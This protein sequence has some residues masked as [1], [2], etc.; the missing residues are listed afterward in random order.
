VLEDIAMA[1]LDPR[2]VQLITH[3]YLRRV[4]ERS[5]RPLDE[6]NLNEIVR[7]MP[8]PGPRLVDMAMAERMHLPEDKRMQEVA[9]LMVVKHLLPPDAIEP[10][11][12]GL[13][14]SGWKEGKECSLERKP[15]PKGYC[16]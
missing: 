8:L 14:R 7:W 13:R 9:E 16:S 5:Y 4:Q 11:W 12:C 1:M 15:N 10:V 2:M 3:A 6:S